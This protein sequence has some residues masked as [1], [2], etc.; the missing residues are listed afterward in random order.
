MRTR[1]LASALH[2][3]LCLIVFPLA[4]SSALIAGDAEK[5]KPVPADPLVWKEPAEKPS[6]VE[7]ID[8]KAFPDLRAKALAQ[9][10]KAIQDEENAPQRALQVETVRDD[11]Q[12]Y[13][14]GIRRGD[15]LLKLDDLELTESDKFNDMRK[16]VPQ[17][18]TVWSAKK[19]TQ[20]VIEIQPGKIGVNLSNFRATG[21]WIFKE[22]PQDPRWEENIRLAAFL[23]HRDPALAETCLFHALKAGC[24]VSLETEQLEVSILSSAWR[25]DELMNYAWHAIKAYPKDNRLRSNFVFAAW[26]LNKYPVALAINENAD[27]FPALIPEMQQRIAAHKALAP[28][29][30]AILQ[31]ID[32][33]HLLYQDCLLLRGSPFPTKE[34]D[35]ERFGWRS[36]ML[37]NLFQAGFYRHNIQTDHYQSSAVA[38]NAKNILVTFSFKTG[39]TD[40]KQPGDYT[41]HFSAGVFDLDAPGAVPVAVNGNWAH[42]FGLVCDVNTWRLSQWNKD[43]VTFGTN[44]GLFDAPRSQQTHTFKLAIWNGI[45]QIELDGRTLYSGPVGRDIGRL[46]VVLKGVGTTA[47]VWG[48]SVYELMDDATKKEVLAREINKPYRMKYTRIHR[49]A[50]RWDLESTKDLLEFK[51]DLTLRTQFGELPL[52]IASRQTREKGELF[53]QYGAKLD[54]LSAA[55]LAKKDVL[56]EMLAATPKPNVNESNTHWKA[57]HGAAL[58]GDAE[59]INMLLDAGADI[60]ARTLKRWGQQTP[61]LWAIANSRVESVKTLLARG[62]DINLGDERKNTALFYAER[63]GNSEILKML[64]GKNATLKPTDAVRPPGPP[65][66]DF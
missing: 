52:H 46:G 34:Q 8:A 26:S 62:A 42:M 15:L 49:A 14:L 54:L 39:P 6:V 7:R 17:Q 22:I 20:R 36:E 31:P 5:Q 30:R 9:Y 2:P 32:Q 56:K 35:E 53:L 66:G 48:L 38:T 45:G 57:L 40:P 59:T 47:E 24:P 55:A 11:G 21:I 19:K 60:N 23:D 51:P 33:A 4:L 37:D 63:G 27:L 16:T 10:Q 18:L 64:K 29:K 28:E 12:A 3:L 50:D 61:L 25:F 41:K 1:V 65:P 43:L 44:I 58:S 13:D